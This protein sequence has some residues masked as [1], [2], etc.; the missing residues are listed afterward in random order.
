MLSTA[1]G[2][3]SDVCDVFNREE[4]REHQEKLYADTCGTMVELS[5]K[6]HI[7]ILKWFVECW[8]DEELVDSADKK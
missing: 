8:G 7:G 4:D 3:D 5:I 1:E 2:L 6:H